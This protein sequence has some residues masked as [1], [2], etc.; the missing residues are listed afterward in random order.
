MADSNFASIAAAREPAWGKPP[1]LPLKLLRL[2]GESLEHKKDTVQSDEVRSDRQI[3]DLAE[4]GSSAAG[5]IDFELSAVAWREMIEAGIFGT[6]VTINAAAITA[7]FAVAGQTLTA[8]AGTPFAAVVPGCFLK[9]TGASDFRNNG[10][11]LVLSKTD[12]V[13]TFAAG[14]IASNQAGAT[15]TVAGQQV[16]NG[17]VLQSY[18]IERNVLLSDNSTRQYQVYR[19][20]MIDK[21]SL[22]FESKKIITG[23][24]EFIGR[25]GE[26][27][28]TSMTYAVG[29][30]TLTDNPSDG[31]TAVIGTQTYTFKTALT[32]TTVNG[33]PQ[34]ITANEVLIGLTASDS[35][36]NLIAA[37]NGAAGDGTLY[38]SQTTPNTSAYAQAGAGDTATFTSYAQGTAGNSIATTETFTA[39]GNVFGAATLT[40]GGT[41]VA[42][43]AADTSPVMNGTSNVGNLRKDGVAMGERFKKIDIEIANNLRGLDAIGERGNWDVGIGSIEIT[44]TISAYFKNNRFLA[45]F[46]NHAYTGISYVVT[47]GNGKSVC[48][49]I[50]RLNFSTGGAMIPGKNA[51]MMQDMKFTAILSEIYGATILFSFLD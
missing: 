7:T 18:C 51:D 35:L 8:S 32:L 33:T 19:G 50:P 2:T 27:Y 40:G 5:G 14:S 28:D 30:L 9:V 16:K 43:S 25:Q 21:L 47:D 24:V 15:V 37:N 11:K 34:A 36:D 6:I 12:T 49:H 17:I 31:D 42:Y 29:T 1:A 22:S 41:P 20:M 26:T 3:S 13:L 46:I 38:G 23:K 44:G 45:D 48:I 4:V 39:A 10:P